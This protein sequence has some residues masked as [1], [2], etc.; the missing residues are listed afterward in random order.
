MRIDTTQIAKML[1]VSPQTARRLCERGD[2]KT[3]RRKSPTRKRSPWTAEK[4]E[5][6]RVAQAGKEAAS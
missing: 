4:S 5:V 3:A 6:E 1:E 2:L